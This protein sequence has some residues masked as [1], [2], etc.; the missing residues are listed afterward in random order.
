MKPYLQRYD[1]PTHT[2]QDMWAFGW[3]A[4]PGQTSHTPARLG[5]VSG[6]IFVL[7]IN[8]LGRNLEMKA[9]PNLYPKTN[10]EEIRYA[11]P[12]TLRGKKMRGLLPK[13]GS[14]GGGRYCLPFGGSKQT[15][16][17]FIFIDTCGTR[18]NRL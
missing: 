1:V 7:Y 10:F 18:P 11:T 13:K 5:L 12:T 2:S 9:C 14:L 15:K 8:A 6:T 3:W 17:L 4:T 16:C